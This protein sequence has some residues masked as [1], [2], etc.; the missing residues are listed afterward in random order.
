MD[1]VKSTFNNMIKS[2]QYSRFTLQ[3]D[4]EADRHVEIKLSDDPA[5]DNTEVGQ[6]DCSPS[7][8]PAPQGRN[9]HMCFLQMMGFLLIFIAG[10]FVAYAI[11][12]RSAVDPVSCGNQSSAVALG[13]QVV[14][15]VTEKPQEQEVNKVEAPEDV[16]VRLNWQDIVQLLDDKLTRQ[17]FTARLKDFD[18]PTRLAGGKGDIHQGNLIAEEFKKLALQSW[19]DVHYVQLQKPDR[20][21][22]NTVTFGSQIFKPDG[23]LAYSNTGKVEGK[24]VY[25]SYGRPEDLDNVQTMKVELNGS[26]L[27]LRAGNLS[28]AEQVANAEARGAAA[29]LIYPDLEDYSYVADTALYGHVHLGSGDPYTPGFPS[30]N[31]TQ[32]PPTQSSGLPKIPAQ[33]ITANMARTLLETIGGPGNRGGV[34]NITVEVNNVLVNTELHNVFGVIKGVVDPDQ[35]VVLGAQRDAWGKGYAR[36]AVGSSVLLELAKAIS[37]MV[38][39]GGFQPRRSLVFA[40]WS[41]GEYGS[42]G[43]TEFLEGYL[44][45]LDKR[46]CTYISLDGMV[47]GRGGFI[48]SASPLLESLLENTMKQVQS[49][50]NGG[51]LYDMVGGTNWEAKVLKPMSVDDPAYPFLA[52]AGIPSISFHFINPNAKTEAYMYYGTSM[53]NMDHLNYNTAQHTAEMTLLAA[54]FT[55]RMALRLIHDRLLPLDVSRYSKVVSKALRKVHRNVYQLVMDGH[56]KGVDPDWLANAQGS[57]QRAVANLKITIDQTD[58]SQDQSCRLLNEKLMSV[59][60][61]LLSPYV[62]IA[63]TPF[64]HILIGQGPHTLASIAEM[65]DKKTEE[66]HTLLAYATWNVKG[67]ANAMMSDIWEED[68]D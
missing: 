24:L 19:T 48:A 40:S 5:D 42:V 64:R 57:F 45:S 17:A 61:N 27:L 21:R 39:K 63:E 32:F 11:H 30:F 43:A 44:S 3:R 52:F 36:A 12:H 31:H 22:P 62:S 54:Q 66:L 18:V 25:G 28:F 10:Y 38:K 7:F 35:Y 37:E 8:R 51:T 14:K 50:L 26:V 16:E 65:N 34:K 6:G 2:V 20:E 68:D 9:R 56:L 58:L 41:A 67:C 49:P 29:V 4:E 60:Q 23:Y 1:R 15:V 47:W 46:M 33:T 53:D 13:D 59:E 55:G